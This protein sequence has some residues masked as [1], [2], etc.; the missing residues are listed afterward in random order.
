[1]L[2]RHRETNMPTQSRM[3]LSGERGSTRRRTT[4][5]WLLLCVQAW[6]A[7]VPEWFLS[8]ET[9]NRLNE[10]SLWRWIQ[11]EVG[12]LPRWSCVPHHNLGVISY[13]GNGQ[14]LPANVLSLSFMNT[15]FSVPKG[16]SLEGQTLKLKL[17][18]SGHLM[19]RTDLP[20]RCFQGWSC[21]HAPG[22]KLGPSW[23]LGTDLAIDA[24][25]LLRVSL[26]AGVLRPPRLGEPT[27]PRLQPQVRAGDLRTK[28]FHS[29]QP[30]VQKHTPCCSSPFQWLEGL[31]S[32]CALMAFSRD[33]E[34]HGDAE[35]GGKLEKGWRFPAFT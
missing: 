17:Q 1:M 33:S 26:Q 28:C 23:W 21:D 13:F 16:N 34:V 5:T 32:L 22:W 6:A 15:S 12:G 27:P 19:W 4:A 35:A 9:W 18:Y 20:G 10:V 11:V 30:Q 29:Q 3:A 7:S 2:W 24:F 8:E 31:I 25:W 14:Q